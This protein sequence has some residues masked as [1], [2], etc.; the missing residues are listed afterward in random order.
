MAGKI[1]GARF[2]TV[3]G[4]GHLPPLEQPFVTTRLIADFLRA[5]L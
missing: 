4:A 5:A 1:K 3:A 2:A